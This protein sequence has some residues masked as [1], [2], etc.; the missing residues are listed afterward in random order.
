MGLRHSQEARAS[1]EKQFFISRLDSLAIDL[2]PQSPDLADSL[3]KT[4]GNRVGRRRERLSC[5]EPLSGGCSLQMLWPHLHSQQ[6]DFQ[7][8]DAEFRVL[9]LLAV[10]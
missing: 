3:L 7:R 2:C 6:P 9:M 1:A 8:P 4:E 10:G 5:K